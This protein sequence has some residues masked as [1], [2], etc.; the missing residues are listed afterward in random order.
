MTPRKKI[1]LGTLPILI[2]AACSN[3]TTPGLSK[4]PSTQS[5]QVYQEDLSKLSQ[6]QQIFES[7]DLHGG[8]SQITLNIPAG[9]GKLVS[10][11]NAAFAPTYALS[12][13][14][15]LGEQI[16]VL[17]NKNLASELT[18]PTGT[19]QTKVVQNG[20]I[21][22]TAKNGA[23]KVSLTADG[24]I[25]SDL[26]ADDQKTVALSYTYSNFESFPLSGAMS[27]SDDDLLAAFPVEDWIKVG[28]FNAVQK[29]DSGSAYFTYSRVYNS[30]SVYAN[31]CETSK[32]D[33][34]D[35]SAA[36]VNACPTSQTA[37]QAKQT[38]AQKVED[39]FPFVAGDGGG[40]VSASYLLS[41]GTITTF[42]GMR[43]WISNDPELIDY[44]IFYE[45]A[46]GHVYTGSFRKAG[47]HALT[48]RVD[49]SLED[50]EI[51]LNAKAVS[52]IQK[53][54][55]T[56]AQGTGDDS[57][58]N[59]THKTPD[60]FGIGGHGVN[61]SLSAADLRSH[62]N[63]PDVL[64]GAG[65]T[66]VIIGGTAEGNFEDDLKVYSQANQLPICD[67][68][69]ANPLNKQ[70]ANGVSLT[71]CFQHITLTNSTVDPNNPGSV[72]A[73]VGAGGEIAL[74]LEM[75][76]ALAPGANIVLITGDSLLDALQTAANYSE[77]ASISSSFSY[78]ICA[79]LNNKD[80]NR[81]C[82]N[83]D[84]IP[85]AAV[86]KILQSAQ[87]LNGVPVFVASGDAGNFDNPE[88]NP[89]Y[90]TV[91]QYVTAV[92]GARV[93]SVAPISASNADTLWTYAG[94]GYGV[95]PM[96]TFQKAL[97][98]GLKAS[99]AGTGLRSVP[100]VVAVADGQY[101]AVE[102]YHNGTWELV[103]GTSVASPVWAGITALIAHSVQ[104]NNPYDPNFDPTNYYNFN[105]SYAVTKTDGGFNGMLYGLSAQNSSSASGFVD[106]VSGT[107]DLL[108]LNLPYMQASAGFDTVSGLGAPDVSKLSAAIV[109]SMKQTM[110]AP[111]L[112]T[113]PD[114]QLLQ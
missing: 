4:N 63:V 59:L 99:A 1:Y 86:E 96:P 27:D 28:N 80:P 79:D 15:L 36:S 8:S 21:V 82:A 33:P 44:R 93:H 68:R 89:G 40:H 111:S 90:P 87:A 29:W 43:A 45:A 42:Q 66:V 70:T 5:A 92:G 55:I 108:G 37:T 9:G 81:T 106:I 64:T 98:G 84:D 14:L 61:G 25:H 91:S 74:D 46:D 56:G 77:A 76:H 75:A 23:R 78:D 32:T 94:S 35:P 17:Q 103:G 69:H 49:G 11:K 62:Y 58:D 57:G 73:Y 38:F 85:V 47:T 41:D 51:R 6:D 101:S 83:G 22:L 88:T 20:G 34:S 114:L 72:G 110:P 102:V 97:A 112:P 65:Q 24:K 39:V 12:Q 26:L 60:L 54:L 2:L 95:T 31:D 18:A 71:P 109:N 67:S 107:N 50:V 13:S 52:S 113:I 10:G 19:S 53:G 3:Y 30:D 7:F 104:I 100:D 105:L 48:A 16:E